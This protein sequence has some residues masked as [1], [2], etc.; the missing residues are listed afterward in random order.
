MNEKVSLGRECGMALPITLA[1]MAILS[2]LVFSIGHRGSLEAKSLHHWV[3]RLEEEQVWLSAKAVVKSYLKMHDPKQDKIED[4]SFE[5]GGLDM[6]ASFFLVNNAYNINNLRLAKSPQR[7]PAFSQV[8]QDHDLNIHKAS[9]EGWIL[10]GPEPH[11]DLMSLDSNLLNVMGEETL[12]W[13]Y[14]HAPF[15]TVPNGSVV[16]RLGPVDSE[17][18]TGK[19][20]IF[21]PR[22]NNLQLVADISE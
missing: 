12:G 17:H 3:D 20:L 6:N 7:D 14:H 13:P 18:D 11:L 16:V 15:S 19:V 10:S 4:L 5:M 22:F 21:E 2:V 1:V 8:I 9:L